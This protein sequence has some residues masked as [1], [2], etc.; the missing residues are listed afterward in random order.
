M[1]P[2]RGTR[3]SIIHLWRYFPSVVASHRQK[4]LG[5]KCIQTNGRTMGFYANQHLASRHIFDA[6]EP[7]HD[8][9]R[10][11]R[12]LGHRQMRWIA[13]RPGSIP[14]AEAGTEGVGG[15][16]VIQQVLTETGEILDL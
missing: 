13:R 3:R 4:L 9:C 12:K 14:E 1:W 10:L 8:Q 16:V 5:Q 7:P 11:V 6:E 2:K 15:Y